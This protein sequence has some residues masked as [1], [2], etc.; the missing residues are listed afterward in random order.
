MGRKHISAN[1]HWSGNGRWLLGLGCLLALL[2][3]ADD[4][5]D[6]SATAEA[7]YSG[8]TFHGY[9][10]TRVA[11]E[12]RSTSR[13]HKVTICSPNSSREPSG[14]S[15]SR[16]TRTVTLAP[17]ARAILPLLQPPLPASG[18]G[19]IRVTVDG[20]DEGTI[21]QPN[22]NNHFT[23]YG[24]GKFTA[25]VFVSRSLDP[26]AINRVFN[27]GRSA[28][29]ASMAVGAP[30]AR[31]TK[32]EP[33]TW[34]PD[35]RRTGQTNWLEL[36]YDPPQTVN[37]LCI[38][39]TQTPVTNGTLT[40][41]DVAGNSIATPLALG[42][43]RNEGIRWTSKFA[44]SKMT[45]PVVTVRLDFGATS[46]GSIAI[47]A[48]EISGATGSQWASNARAS[49]DNSAS[50]PRSAAGMRGSYG[51]NA[52]SIQSLRAESV[53]TDWSEDW[54][55]YT[56]FDMIAL[57]AADLTTMP[58]P[59]AAAIGNYI[60]AGGNVVIFGG[61]NLPKVWPVTRQL[62]LKDGLE[63][64]SGFGHCFVLSGG[65][66]G[67]AGTQTMRI[68]RETAAASV[69]YWQSLP[70]DIGAANGALPI[71][72][73]LII[74]ARGIVIM[75][76]LFI[77]VIGPLNIF[78]LVRKNRRTW[79]LWT[80]PTISF[81]TTLVVFAYSLL[82]EGVSPNMRVAGLTVLDQSNHHAATIGAT[83]FYC[84]LTPGGGL[85]FDSATEA[86]PL[87]AVG[88][89]RSGGTEREVDW[90]QGQ[91][92]NRGWV[93]SRVPAHFHLRKSETR[94]ERLEIINENGLLHVVNGLGVSIQSIWMADT[95][96]N[97][98]E[99]TNITVGQKAALTVLKNPPSSSKLGVHDL[100]RDLGFV[101][102]AQAV[103]SNVRKYLQPGTYVAVLDG[104]PFIENALGAAA[105]S[106]R[107]RSSALVY[108][109]LEST[110]A[111]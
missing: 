33:R 1:S 63:Y 98:Y 14:N 21:H 3:R 15:I 23:Q 46:P 16:I 56:P 32:P 55:A 88:Y 78:I 38:Y 99:A 6:L 82:R 109:I 76:L 29:S 45:N 105:A 97:Y 100:L 96:L 35:E 60:Q 57:G 51:Y 37:R 70:A 73:N 13:T 30:D 25:T 62:N 75:M 48:V 81:A 66:P 49:S 84:P 44:I 17:G 58:A 8:N 59:V 36:D 89:N 93:V 39:Q 102:S 26:D 65:D 61:T 11:L 4:F 52:D 10:E 12:N 91:H 31:G 67:Q 79:L 111:K 18:D 53:V 107:T 103:D 87:V 110:V 106:K 74:P 24:R 40:L 47:D 85:H 94:R 101:A 92:F 95:N 64:D 108:G 20:H 104:N 5:G 41:T 50:S 77:I 90:S 72:E 68:L 7:M 69:L 22:S 86:T 34:V 43:N 28:Y 2:C 42:T 54:M 19:S 27:A 9:A 83:G 80:I 71:V